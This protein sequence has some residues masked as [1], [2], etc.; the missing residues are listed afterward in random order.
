MPAYYF[1]I[2]DDEVLIRDPQGIELSD[3]N[4]VLDE[5]RTLILST[6]REEQSEEE[7]SANWEF[8]IE[9]DRG[10]IVLVVPFRLARSLIDV[11][12]GR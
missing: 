12:G 5:C 10:R 11:A 4:A 9:D 7:M 8:Q 6:I 2:R 3:I 1:H